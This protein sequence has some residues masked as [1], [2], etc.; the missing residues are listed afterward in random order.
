[1]NLKT[2][3][4]AEKA[5]GIDTVKEMNS[6]DASDLKKIIVEASAAMQ[7]AKDELEANAAYNQ[8]KEDVG[9][10]SAG[11]REVD[12]RQK[13]RIAYALGLLEEKGEAVLEISVPL[14]GA[15]LKDIIGK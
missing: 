15:T 2:L 7:V 4:K 6:L 11:K 14:K 10:L 5:L 8:A 12:K 13:A 3:E 1:M 9:I